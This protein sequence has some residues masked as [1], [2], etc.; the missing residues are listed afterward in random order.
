MLSFG[1]N[2]QLSPIRDAAEHQQESIHIQ[3]WCGT[4]PANPTMHSWLQ[5]HAISRSA[6][7]DVVCGMTRRQSGAVKC[8]I[9][10]V[11]GFGVER[12]FANP[13]LGSSTTASQASDICGPADRCPEN[14]TRNSLAVWKLTGLTAGWKV[15]YQLLVVQ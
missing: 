14:V 2:Q 1:S 11:L 12:R 7:G 3:L 15:L 9:H 13:T 4:P 10:V 5:D 8:F 6:S